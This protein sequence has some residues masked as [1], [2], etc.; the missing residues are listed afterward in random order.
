[1]FNTN[2]GLIRDGIRENCG[3]RLRDDFMSFFNDRES[4]KSK[5]AKNLQ[6]KVKNLYLIENRNKC[7][8]YFQIYSYILEFHMYLKLNS[9]INLVRQIFTFYPRLHIRF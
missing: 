6:V 4:Q 7:E 9:A 2:G 5:E 8:M 1:M 3:A